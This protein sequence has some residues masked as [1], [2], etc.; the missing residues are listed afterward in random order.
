[1]FYTKYFRVVMINL[2][3]FLYNFR[4]TRVISPSA[5]PRFQITLVWL[6]FPKSGIKLTYRPT[7]IAA[8]TKH[9]HNIYT[10]LNQRQSRWAGVVWMLY[11]CFVFA[12]LRYCDEK[13]TVIWIQWTNLALFFL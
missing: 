4:P 5:L 6:D 7:H 3:P 1:M 8:N 2:K 12:G 11:Q 13:A 9:L 10:M